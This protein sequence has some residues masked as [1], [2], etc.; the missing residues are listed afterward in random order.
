MNSNKKKNNKKA[1]FNFKL[2]KLYEVYYMAK[3][4]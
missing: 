1:L 2:F 3:W 4:N